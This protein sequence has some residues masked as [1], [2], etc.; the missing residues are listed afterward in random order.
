MCHLVVNKIIFIDM[1]QSK[2]LEY[3]L[4]FCQWLFMLKLLKEKRKHYWSSKITA[5]HWHFLRMW[6]I[7]KSVILR[8]YANFFLVKDTLKAFDDFENKQKGVDKMQVLKKFPSDK[9]NGTKMSSFFFRE[10]RLITVLLF[11]CHSYMS[12]STRFLK[13]CVWDFPFSILFRFYQSLYFYSTK[14]MESLTL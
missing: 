14:C 5:D 8:F 9:I 12:W 3:Y 13:N 2:Q 4:F 1:Y 10:F 11:I 7:I 6:K